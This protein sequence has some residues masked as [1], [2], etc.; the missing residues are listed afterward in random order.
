MGDKN[1]RF[2]HLSASLRK[3][4]NYIRKIEQNGSHLV[5]LNNVKEGVVN[6][7]S[8]LFKPKCKRIDMGHLRFSKISEAK[9]FWLERSPSIEEV[10]QAVWD[11]DGSKTPGPDGYTFSFNKK[12]WNIISLYVFMMVRDFSK[13]TKGYQLFLYN[14]N[15]KNKE[16]EQILPIWF[17]KLDL[18]VI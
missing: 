4:R 2:S 8:T 16:V 5:S 3:G 10:K 14:S 1:T 9:L 17:D 6:S 7:F 12:V 11:C 15:S 13:T 18:W